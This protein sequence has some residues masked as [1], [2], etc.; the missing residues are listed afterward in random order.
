[1]A[2]TKKS[3]SVIVQVDEAT[4]GIME[5]ITS[6]ITSEISEPLSE[7]NGYVNGISD[8]AND[9][10]KQMRL[11]NSVSTQ[12]KKSRRIFRKKATIYITW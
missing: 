5:S 2:A 3:D 1:M 6:G 8:M 4:K 12:I 7:L 9:L 10:L 11:S